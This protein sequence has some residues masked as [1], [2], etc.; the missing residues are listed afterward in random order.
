M[1]TYSIVQLERGEARDVLRCVKVGVKPMLLVLA[2]SL[3]VGCATGGSGGSKDSLVA[4]GATPL[5]ASELRALV[6]DAEISGYGH[7]GL[8]TI[9]E[10]DKA[11]GTSSGSVSSTQ[12]MNSFTGTWSIDGSGAYCVDRHGLGDYNFRDR[13]CEY[14]YK[15][16]TDY[17]AVRGGLAV[18]RTVKR[19]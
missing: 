9:Y 11:D 7:S 17:Y 13:A 6:V 4:Q 1:R 8:G 10:I 15:L 3:V 18:K 12:G 14:W 16:G 2:A 5:S 19:L